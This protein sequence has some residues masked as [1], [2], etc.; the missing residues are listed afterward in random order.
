M[1]IF[2]SAERGPFLKGLFFF[3]VYV[4]DC[5]S[6]IIKFM[7]ELIKYIISRVKER[8]KQR[9]TKYVI[10]NFLKGGV[11]KIFRLAGAPLFDL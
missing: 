9:I 8:E 4:F 2:Y 6:V 5:A 11:Y 7:Y 10:M 1:F 3:V